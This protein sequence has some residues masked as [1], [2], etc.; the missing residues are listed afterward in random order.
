MQ[1]SIG[2]IN[3]GEYL[4]F[5]K[6]EK[7]PYKH[8]FGL[9]GGKIEEGEGPDRAL[10]REI[11]EESG[12]NVEEMSYRGDLYE[13]LIKDDGATGVQLSI[14]SALVSGKVQ[15]NKTEGEIHLVHPDKLSVLKDE[16]IPTDWMI[17]KHLIKNKKSIFKINIVYIVEKNGKYEVIFNKS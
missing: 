14:Y 7:P 16:F 17:T 9:I 6:R 13:V 15:A 4:V 12:L 10:I 11:K 2:L 8:Y 5:Q 1:V 3:Y